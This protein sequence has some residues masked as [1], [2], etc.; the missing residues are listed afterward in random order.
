MARVTKPQRYQEILSLPNVTVLHHYFKN[1]F[2]AVRGK[3]N[4]VFQN[5][6]PITLE[7]ACG[8]GDYALALGN[9][10]PDR[11]FIGIDIKGDRLW[12]GALTALQ[13]NQKNVHFLRARIEH[14]CN[15]FAPSEVDEIWITFPDPF[16][17]TRKKRKR[18]THP[19]FLQK[20]AEILKPDGIVH[21]K[22]DSD[23]LFEFTRKI[24]NIFNLPVNQCYNNMYRFRDRKEEHNI[25]TYYE[26]QHLE[27]G[28]S[29]KYVSF[30]LDPGNMDP[31]HPALDDLD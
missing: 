2:A 12:K 8:K 7:L 13:Q 15:Y 4:S 14:I 18:L 10:Y 21:L 11:N 3:W 28:L 25:Q 22:T 26:R 24:I 29:I 23:R 5:D 16:E 1:D 31:D 27:K 17:K 20:Y 30:Q 9:M 19:L 6:N